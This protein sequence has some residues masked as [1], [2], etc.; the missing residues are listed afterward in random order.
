M[1]LTGP[2][3]WLLALLAATAACTACGAPDAPAPVRAAA[4]ASSTSSAATAASAVVVEGDPCADA[5]RYGDLC[6]SVEVGGRPYRYAVVPGTGRHDGGLT[7]LD[8]GGPGASLFGSG[9]PTDALDGL[10]TGRSDV[11]LLEEPWVIAAYPDACRGAVTDWYR[12]LRADVP[13]RPVPT[14]R[15]SAVGR[16]CGLWS[17]RWGWTPASYGAVL[18]AVLAREGRPVERFVGF[19]F[20]STRLGYAQAAGVAPSSIALLSPFPTGADAGGWL[21]AREQQLAGMPEPAASVVGEQPASR[22]LELAA[23]DLAAARVQL[24]YGD[25]GVLDEVRTRR[26]DAA[27]VGQLSDMLF[28]RYDVD[29]LS[30]ALLALWDETCPALTGWPAAPTGDRPVSFL[31][32]F[33]AVC[34]AAPTRPVVPAPTSPPATSGRAPGVCVVTSPTDG[35]VP[36]SVVV[37]WARARGWSVVLATGRHGDPAFVGRCPAPG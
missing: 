14:A 32:E 2:R 37:P 27:L 15:T 16:A 26:G 34:G 13:T 36:R 35:V 18:D 29:E 5:G 28:G 24:Q 22:S 33:T 31:Q 3:R 17:G 21:A 12:A 6:R 30:P 10:G 11:L 20:G 7:L 9:W 19:S 4:S 23:A 8:P 1:E 25:P